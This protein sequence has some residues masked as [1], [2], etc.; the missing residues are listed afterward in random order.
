MKL[1]V[2]YITDQKKHVIDV[3]IKITWLYSWGCDI[4]TYW[5]W[6]HSPSFKIFHSLLKAKVHLEKMA[7]TYWKGTVFDYPKAIE[8]LRLLENV[9]PST[10]IEAK[11]SRLRIMT[12]WV[13]LNS[14]FSWLFTIDR[15]WVFVLR[16][17]FSLLWIWNNFVFVIIQDSFW[18]M[19]LMSWWAVKTV[20]WGG[21]QHA[22][23]FTVVT[24]D[25]VRI[26]VVVI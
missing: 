2:K 10:R 1:I 25:I 18:P 14:F 23:T 17:F 7:L 9:L 21:L 19:S 8:L 4:W 26:V 16:F 3:L 20:Q 13:V 15:S 22:V 6:P 11:L 12:C 24:D 5:F